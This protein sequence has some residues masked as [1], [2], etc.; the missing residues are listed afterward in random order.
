MTLLSASTAAPVIGSV[1]LTRGGWTRHSRLLIVLCFVFNMI[2]GMDILIMSFISPALQRAWRLSPAEMSVIFSA[3]LCGMAVGGVLVAPLA[4]RFGRRPLILI[5]LCLM[6]AAMIASSA[7]VS[8][9]YLVM[10][11]VAIGIGIG[12]V[13]ACI[14]ALAAAHAP[15]RNR[16]FAVGILQAGYPMGATIAGFLTAFYLPVWGWRSILFSTG[17]A[18]AVV[19]PF[20]FA[21]LPRS[22]NEGPSRAALPIRAVLG[23]TRLRSTLLLWIATICSFMALY[24]IASWITRLAIQAGLPETQAIFASAIYNIGSFCGVLGMSLASTRV[25]I[26]LLAS[27]LLAASAAAFLWFGG[28]RMSVAF[29]LV[30]AFVM[31]IVLQGG[32]NALYPLAARVYPD[33]VRATGIGWAMGVGRIGAFTG[34]LL[35]G[36]ALGLQWPLVAVFSLF[37]APLLVAALCARSVRFEA[38]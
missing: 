10:A 2:D 30:A 7:A 21:L 27:G 36:W 25:D 29:V 37:C 38:Q 26:R 32:F 5:A 8:M 12:T 17:V 11:R 31:G 28:V 14:A 18:S 9:A 33:Q 13:L 1:P 22:A 23:E 35:G 20:A 19:L 24:F 34:P 3:G 6:A 4:D 15:A 16:D